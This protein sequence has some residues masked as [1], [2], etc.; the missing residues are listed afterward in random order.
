MAL[1]DESIDDMTIGLQMQQFLDEWNYRVVH[2]SMAQEWD[3]IQTTKTAMSLFEAHGLVIPEEEKEMLAEMDESKMVEALV[4]K[5][6]PSLRRT[7][8]HFTLQLQLF[9]SAATRVR[10]ALDDGDDGDV[11]RTIEEGDKAITMQILKQTVVEAAAEVSEI[12]QVH[13]SWSYS[14]NKRI[15]RLAR[16]AKTTDEARSELERINQSIEDF[17]RAQNQK[18][19]RVLVSMIGANDKVLLKTSFGGWHSYHVKYLAEKDIHLKFR[20]EIE[21]TQVKLVQYK[22]EKV[23]NV[24]KVMMQTLE[25]ATQELLT[26]VVKQWA[27]AIR[28]E[29]EEKAAQKALEEQMANLEGLKESQKANAKQS[30]LRM[31]DGNDGALTSLC[32][33][34]WAT[35]MEEMRLENAYDKQTKDL[36]AQFKNMRAQKSGENKGVLSRFTEAS[37]TGLVTTVFKAWSDEFK[38]E[39]RARD[40]QKQIDASDSRFKCM[41]MAQKGKAMNV[42]ERVAELEAETMMMSAFMNWQME[43]KL[44]KVNRH[45]K[46]QMED[47]KGQLD[48]VRT[49]FTDFANELGDVSNSPRTSKRKSKKDRSPAPEESRGAPSALQ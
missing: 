23:A 37:D 36:E 9:V 20:A 44:D 11:R 5:M 14:M 12:K 39:K 3:Q 25:N 8:E 2:A 15:D 7:F 49:L 35:S 26:E 31:V 33:Q 29:K 4:R 13:D 27:Q 38:Q 18:S 19:Q 24:R 41:Q 45:Y 17:G 42:S 10:S 6:S 40:F 28:D 34:T 21:A 32:F 16:T 47:K 22:A 1:D 43:T 30:L 46:Q 48:F